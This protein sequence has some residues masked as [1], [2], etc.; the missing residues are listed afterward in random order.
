MNRSHRFI[1][2]LIVGLL[3]VTVHTEAQGSPTSRGRANSE[4]ATGT[5]DP[6]TVGDDDVRP[7][8]RK[9]FHSGQEFGT[10]GVAAVAQQ[11]S[12]DSYD[13]GVSEAHAD[14]LHAANLRLTGAGSGYGGLVRAGYESAGG[15]RFGVG[16]GATQVEGVSVQHG[17]LPEG[18]TING[19]RVVAANFQATFGKGLNAEYFYPYID[20]KVSL[21]VVVADLQLVT[22]E[23]GSMGI[24]SHWVPSVSVAPRIGAVVPLDSAAFMDVSV[25]YGLFGAERLGGQVQFGVMLDLR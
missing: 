21:N 17:L 19:A 1:F 15:F 23:Y 9:G 4:E 14:L 25:E 11:L 5:T 12:F 18:V 7:P 3:W 8:R 24:S 6:T 20:A 2:V 10:L 22:L 13:L 16:V